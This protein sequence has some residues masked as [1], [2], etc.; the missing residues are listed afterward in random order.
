MPAT[1]T[2]NSCGKA[3]TPWP[4]PATPK[5]TCAVAETNPAYSSYRGG[6]R[7]PPYHI[8]PEAYQALYDPAAI[9]LR[10]NVPPDWAEKRAA[11]ARPGTTPIARPWT[12]A[13][14]CCSRPY[15]RR[16]WSKRRS[17]C[18]SRITATCSARRAWTKKQKPYE[19]SIRVPFLLRYPGMDAAELDARIDLPDIMPTLLGLCDLPIPATRGGESTFP[20]TYKAA[21]TPRDG[22]ALLQCPHPFGQWWTGVWRPVVQGLTHPPPHVTCAP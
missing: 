8:A 5:R 17:F 6:R 21:Q 1:Q 18:S 20:R 9:S 7:T 15:K 22:A 11:V 13:S 3:T 2:S 19:E 14:A 16:G 4:R 10:P 12:T